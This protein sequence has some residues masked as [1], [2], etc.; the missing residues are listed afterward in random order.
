MDIID[1]INNGNLEQHCFDLFNVNLSK[2]IAVLSSAYPELKQELAEIEDMIEQFA[3][4][5]AIIPSDGLKSRIISALD[6]AAEDLDIKNLPPT[7]QY[8]NYTQWLNAVE[9][10]IPDEPFEDFFA[11]LLKQDEHI[12]QT[13]VIT[14]LDVPEELHEAT[15]ESFFILKGQCA[16]TVG[17]EVFMLNAGDYLDI[18]LHVNHDIKILSP[19]VIAILQHQF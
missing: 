19:Y 18:P 6:F 4:S 13:L 9:H 14:R 10:L 1:Y 8:S 15:A 17:K 2:E 7:S 11:E 3:I 12:A 5:Q 16:C